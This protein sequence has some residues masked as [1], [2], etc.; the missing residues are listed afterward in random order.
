MAALSDPSVST[1]GLRKLNELREAQ[2]I[3][4][5]IKTLPPG[6]QISVSATAFVTALSFLPA[7]IQYIQQMMAVP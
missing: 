1:E 4:S 5:G 2:G 3:I 7:G 6:G